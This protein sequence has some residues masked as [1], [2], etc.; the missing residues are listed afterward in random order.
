MSDLEDIE[1]IFEGWLEKPIEEE[2][3][4]KG[5]LKKSFTKKWKKA[6]YVLR[7]YCAGNQP[8]LQ[9]FDKEDGWRRQ[10]PRGTL[11][12]FP[13]YKVFKRAEH[14]D[15]QY[16]FE[17]STDAESLIL[18]AESETVLDLWVIQLQMQTVMNPRIPGEVFRVKGSG[19]RQMQRIGARDQRC[20][21]HLSKWG[22]TLALERTRAVLA[23]W[24]LTTIRSYE[25][26][27]ANE[28]IFEAGRA[29]PMGEGKYNFFTQNGEDNKIFDVIDNFAS[30]RLRRQQGIHSPAASHS[31]L[32]DDDIERAYDQLRF[33]VSMLSTV[34]VPPSSQ[35]G[36][37]RSIN[38]TAPQSIDAAGSAQGMYNHLG[39]SDSIGSAHSLG[40]ISI[41]SESNLSYNRLERLPSW[42]SQSSH[43]VQRGEQYN[44][45]NAVPSASSIQESSYDRLVRSPS[46]SSHTL[47]QSMTDSQA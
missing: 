8:F 32:T 9:W 23:Q 26:L 42:G 10:M 30:A 4:N 27:D 47:A 29:S 1:D 6:F 17:I 33:S 3:K 37:M 45:L 39:R 12:L 28:F 43:P 7:K 34:S 25:A 46:T 13:R 40:G 31:Q 5:W 2:T 21:L 44:R 14:K 18:A 11:E 24:P 15:K 16:V 19:S 22:M 35:D 36:S 38:Q 20:L 41:N